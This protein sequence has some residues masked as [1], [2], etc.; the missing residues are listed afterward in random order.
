MVRPQVEDTHYLLSVA[1]RGA[2]AL[3]SSGR[4]GLELAEALKDE[5]RRRVEAHEFF[6]HISYA[7]LIA[8]RPEQSNH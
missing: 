4:I 3:A 1:D 8:K 7:S 6:G 2:A 5:A